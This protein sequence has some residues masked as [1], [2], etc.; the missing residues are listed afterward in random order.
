M[1][2]ITMRPKFVARVAVEKVGRPTCSCQISIVLFL[3]PFTSCLFVV[4]VKP[5]D[6]NTSIGLSLVGILLLVVL[7]MDNNQRILLRSVLIFIK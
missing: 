4:V 5:F 3:D 6:Y 1:I 7:R 2:D